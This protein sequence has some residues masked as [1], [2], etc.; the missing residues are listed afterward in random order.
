MVNKLKYS[1]IIP[2]YNA[3]ETLR[4]CIDS[5]TCQLRE[6]VQIILVN[7]GSSDRSGE[8][9]LE[10]AER[11]SAIEYIHQGNYGVSNARNTGLQHARGVYVTFVDS[12]DYVAANYFSVLDKAE[13][14]DLLVFAHENVGGAPLDESKLFDDL[15]KLAT[16]EQ[17]LEL[18]LSSR[19]IMAPWNKRF[20][21]DIIQKNSLRFIEGLSVGED[22]NFCMAYAMQSRSV[23]VINERLIYNDTSDQQSLS[24]RYR[25]Q[26]DDKLVSVFANVNQTIRNSEIYKTQIDSFLTITDFLYVKHVFSC[27]SEEFKRT[28]LKYCRD[29][30]LVVGICEKFRHPISD[31]YCSVVHWALRLALKWRMY[32]PFYLVC[33]WVKGRRY[34]N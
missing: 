25:S 5:F 20:R 8:I 28:R 17:K 31:K 1:I 13:D 21:A 6:D 16:S 32:Y 4:C 3:E 12:D 27:I 10:Y 9:A 18:L 15:Q 30:K 14:C 23:Q 29:R 22:F 34:S 19:K 2:V 11:Y 33:Y 26:L 7:D 24:R